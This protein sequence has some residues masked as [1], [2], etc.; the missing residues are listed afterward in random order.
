[1]N[2]LKTIFGIAVIGCVSTAQGALLSLPEETKVISSELPALSTLIGS[3]ENIS[4]TIAK[5][6]SFYQKISTIALSATTTEGI[7]A[8]RETIEKLGRISPISQLNECGTIFCTMSRAFNP[9]IRNEYEE[10]VSEK[11]STYTTATYTSFG[12]S[13]LLQDFIIL[14]KALEKNPKMSL[15]VHLIDVQYATY[16]LCL[17]KIT[18]SY[19][20]DET[21]L[22]IA[23][24]LPELVKEKASFSHQ[25][26]T[27]AKKRF[28]NEFLAAEVKVQQF[29][30]AL[31]QYFPEAPLTIL[32]HG[33]KENYCNDIK[34]SSREH[35]DILTAIDIFDDLD[36]QQ[37]NTA[38]Q[39]TNLCKDTKK[40][41]KASAC[42]Y[43]GSR[44]AGHKL[45]KI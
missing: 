6:R 40:E 29:N 36:A 1:M 19:V 5:N 21:D 9:T 44:N 43:V 37:Y 25:N 34:E 16:A 30:R 32:V 31:R 28:C 35:A 38:E 7:Q 23:P 14:A 45:I 17:K 26:N 12:S 4:K 42:I 13:G 20:V 33:S 27:K 39:F 41:K 3:P 22:N 11:L 8:F 24:L 10:C 18:G 2:Y 15:T